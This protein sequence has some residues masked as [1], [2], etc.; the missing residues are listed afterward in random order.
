M[1]A[2]THGSQTQCHIKQGYY[3]MKSNENTDI[4]A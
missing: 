1:T 2:A 3:N 4:T